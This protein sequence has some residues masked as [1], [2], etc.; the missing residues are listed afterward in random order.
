MPNR[1]AGA[2]AIGVEH[3]RDEGWYTP[4][5]VVQEVDSTAAQQYL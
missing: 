3:R 5:L 1:D 4:D 2:L